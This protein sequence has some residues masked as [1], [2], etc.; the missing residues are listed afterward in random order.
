M[1][2]IDSRTIQRPEKYDPKR[3]S[4]EEQKEEE[5]IINNTLTN[6]EDSRKNLA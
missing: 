3:I 4:I 1:N 5:D 2:I 6:Y